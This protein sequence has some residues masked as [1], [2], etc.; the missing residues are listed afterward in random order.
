MARPGFGPIEIAEDLPGLTE[1]VIKEAIEVY[2]LTYNT[3]IEMITEPVTAEEEK[4]LLDSLR[5]E[6][7]SQLMVE[8]P[9]MARR[10]IAKMRKSG[11]GNG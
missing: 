8:D 1:E 6:D 4:R 9:D 11:N 2:D 10:V 3:V 5:S 7:I